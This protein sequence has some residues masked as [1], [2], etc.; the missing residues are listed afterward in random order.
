MGGE[1]TLTCEQCGM[2]NFATLW[3][4]EGA[5]QREALTDNADL[6]VP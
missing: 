1:Q 5:A 6:S 2:D 4:F 3:R